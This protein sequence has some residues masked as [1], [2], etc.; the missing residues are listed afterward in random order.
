MAAEAKTIDAVRRVLYEPRRLAS[1]RDH[2]SSIALLMNLDARHTLPPNDPRWRAGTGPTWFVR[3]GQTLFSSGTVKLNPSVIEAADRCDK[4]ADLLRQIHDELAHVDFDQSDKQ[5]LRAA[6]AQ[7][8]IA[9]RK[10]AAVW[11][12][13]QAPHDPKAAAASIAAHQRL[14]VDELK[15]VTKYLRQVDLFT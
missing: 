14:G 12:E 2:M 7:Q 15:H 9:A 10:R 1:L 13:P 11:R 8:E 6:L 4:V 3:T 5:H